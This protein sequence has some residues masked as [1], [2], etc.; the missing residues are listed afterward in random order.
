[1]T[2]ERFRGRGPIPSADNNPLITGADALRDPRGYRAGPE[3]ANAVNVALALQMPLVVT[4]EPG[5]GKTQLAYRLAAELGKTEVLR[6]DTKS[7]SLAN[8][9]FYQFDSIRQ[10]SQS[11]LN[12]AAQK[13][14]PEAREFL[15]INAMGQAILRTLDPAK[16]TDKLGPVVRHTEPVSSVVMID[17]ID[18]APR[19]F[20]NDLL[21]QIENLEFTIPE[22][23]ASFRADRKFAPIVVITSNSEKQLPEPFLRRCVYHHI[24][25]PTDQTEIEEI[26][27]ARLERTNLTGVAYRE[28]LAFF[29]RLRAHATLVKKP[30]TSELL[31]WL[32]ALSVAGLTTDKSLAE[33]R[34]V[35]ETCLGTLLK[36]SDDVKIAKTLLAA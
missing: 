35:L 15:R 2:F 26:L 22:L 7:S 6:F 19:D 21:N 5:T 29:F 12:A 11:Q 1:M 16:V 13:P 30:S 10:F 25:F 23:G 34:P 33:Q 28:A 24:E 20:P 31:D 17:E 8:E 36:I 14:L 3:L 4:G 27:G 9:L 18:K 32:R